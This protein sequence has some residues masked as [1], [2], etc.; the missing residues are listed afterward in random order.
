VQILERPRP[1]YTA[2]ARQLQIEGEVVLQVSFT[3]QGQVRVIQ[4]LKGLG[5]GL[6]QSA[7]VAA[8]GIRYLPARRD[9]QPIDFP[10]TVHL[11]FQ[12]AY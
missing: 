11:T 9:G 10:G 2:E 1:A 4:V 8:Q 7:I 3:A 6:D 5:H 12:L